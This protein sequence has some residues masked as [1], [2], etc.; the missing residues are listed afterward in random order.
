MLE[1]SY[2]GFLEFRFLST[3][4]LGSPLI[5]Y[6][7]YEPFAHCAVICNGNMEYGARLRADG[8]KAAGVQLRPLNYG[9]TGNPFIREERKRLPVSEAEWATF[10][11]EAEKLL[12]K[13]YSVRTILGF[14][15]DHDFHDASGFDCSGLMAYLMDKM[16]RLPAELDQHLSMITPGGFYMLILGMGFPGS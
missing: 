13:P 4:N 3:R 7:G 8:A 2:P 10:W 1:D 15:L 11:T 16:G 12:G 14:V 6:F 5:E 9:K